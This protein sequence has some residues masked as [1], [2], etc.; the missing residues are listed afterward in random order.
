MARTGALAGKTVAEIAIG[1]SH[2]LARCADGSLAA[3]GG[4]TPDY[5]LPSVPGT[6]NF[7]FNMASS[8]GGS[9][10]VPAGNFLQF[11]IFSFGG[12]RITRYSNPASNVSSYVPGFQAT[13]SPPHFL[14]H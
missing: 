6:G 8:A 1:G 7:T 2:V 5:D 4:N 3:W 13:P 10:V 9:I 14:T 11:Y 12:A